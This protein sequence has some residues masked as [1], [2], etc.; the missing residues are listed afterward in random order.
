MC[1]YGHLIAR[2]ITCGT[3]HTFYNAYT[4]TINRYNLYTYHMTPAMCDENATTEFFIC[5]DLSI[6]EVHI[7]C[8]M[9]LKHICGADGVCRVQYVHCTCIG[10]YVGLNN[11]NCWVVFCC[12]KCIRRL[13]RDS[14]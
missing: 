13:Y 6:I 4:E 7:D 9:L 11:W 12:A 1:V 2:S 5:A 14:I 8:E 3:R 10:I